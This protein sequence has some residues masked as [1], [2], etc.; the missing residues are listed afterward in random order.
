M[1]LRL[2]H[3]CP[4]GTTASRHVP[5]GELTLPALRDEL[6]HRH[7]TAFDWQHGGPRGTIKFIDLH[8][9]ELAAHLARNG[10]DR[11]AT[12]VKCYV[13]GL[14]RLVCKPESGAAHYATGMAWNTPCPSRTLSG[15]AVA[16]QALVV[17]GRLARSCAHAR[18]VA[19]LARFVAAR[20]VELTS[21]TEHPCANGSTRSQVCGRAWYL[22]AIR[23]FAELYDIGHLRADALEGFDQLT[24]ELCARHGNFGEPSS[25]LALADRVAIAAA[26]SEFRGTDS[27]TACARFARR[28]LIDG[29][30]RHA[31][32]AGG[33]VQAYHDGVPPDLDCSI[34]LVRS[35]AA[36]RV[37]P[38]PELARIAAHGKRALFAPELALARMPESGLLMLL[39]DATGNCRSRSPN[40]PL[41]SQSSRF[42]GDWD[43]LL[44]NV[45]K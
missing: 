27:G 2:K 11:A 1:Y 15:Q 38:D 36:L 29:A 22:S 32:P 34:D 35:A 20:R 9:L 13:R 40:T 26:A 28:I 12:M 25:G 24:N 45:R 6:L 18:V 16:I 10:D 30:S 14:E 42:D 31:H 33:W 23:A 39:A 17:V 8:Q 5:G 44:V 21:G 4:S 43:K 19:Q 7:Y 37:G 3:H 41:R